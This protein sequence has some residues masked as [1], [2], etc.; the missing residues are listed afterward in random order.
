MVLFLGISSY[1]RLAS[2]LISKFYQTFSENLSNYLSST[3]LSLQ[4]IL[5]KRRVVFSLSTSKTT[6][7]SALIYLVKLGLETSS[8][9]HSGISATHYRFSCYSTK[10]CTRN[11]RKQRLKRLGRVLQQVT[12]AY[13]LSCKYLLFIGVL[14]FLKPNVRFS[15]QRSVAH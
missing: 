9:C 3:F 5:F 8:R 10:Y 1:R 2:S 14:V 7:Y 13:V 4:D 6:F 12:K 11:S 15:F